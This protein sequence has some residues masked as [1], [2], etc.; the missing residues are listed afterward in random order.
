MSVFARQSVYNLKVASVIFGL[1]C[2]ASRLRHKLGDHGQNPDF[3]MLPNCKE[4]N[5]VIILT[6]G[7]LLENDSRKARQ[8]VCIMLSTFYFNSFVS[9]P[10]EGIMTKQ[11]Q[12][13]T[14]EVKQKYFLH[15]LPLVNKNLM[16]PRHYSLYNNIPLVYLDICGFRPV[17]S[18]KHLLPDPFYIPYSKWAA[19]IEQVLLLGLYCPRADLQ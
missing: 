16:Q 8:I 19:P 5:F 7:S 2:G 15:A 11:Y 10:I 9:S 12:A 4:L 6:S 1:F 13:R 14:N 18:P 3:V 17:Q